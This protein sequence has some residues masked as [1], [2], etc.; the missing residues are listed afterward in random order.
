MTGENEEME[1]AE[2]DTVEEV[3][4]QVEEEVQAPKPAPKPQPRPAAPTPRPQAQAPAVAPVR[5]AEAPAPSPAP[6]ATPEPHIPAGYLP[7]AEVDRLVGE[8]RTDARRKAYLYLSRELGVQLVDENGTTIAPLKSALEEVRGVR[9]AKDARIA[10]LEVERADL[11]GR[12]VAKESEVSHAFAKAQ[13][14]LRLGEAKAQA[15]M[16]GFNDPA[17]AIAMLG[18]LDQ[19]EA[20][21]ETGVVAGLDKALAKL[22]AAKP[23]LIRSTP[24]PDAIPP[25]PSESTARA[26]QAE[27][28]A[29][30]E[31]KLDTVRLQA[32]TYF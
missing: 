32:Q 11:E 17:D 23:Y 15:V 31:D 30:N 27:V 13:H 7:Q 21:I 5:R 16:L 4:Q 28:E 10:E 25:T 18:D 22:A 3:D 20:D 14:M 1:R 26:R 19:F 8:A 6:T 2:Q 24:I 29:V 9:N 12:V